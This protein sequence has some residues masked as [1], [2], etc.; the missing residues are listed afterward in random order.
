MSTT[1]TNPITN[2]SNG[3]N[4]AVKIDWNALKKAFQSSNYLQLTELTLEDACVLA[5]PFVPQAAIAGSV[6]KLL[7]GLANGIP[8]SGQPFDPK[9]LLQ[10]VLIAEGIDWS[11]IKGA[12]MGNNPFEAATMV[13]SDIAKLI[14]PFVTLPELAIP[15]I[16][17]LVVIGQESK[18]ENFDPKDPWFQNQELLEDL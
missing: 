5:G 7:A 6:I 13:T 18:P 15:L 12:L 10:G 17:G 1:S 2:L 16:S 9:K 4:V 14:S 3:L 8:A 11:A